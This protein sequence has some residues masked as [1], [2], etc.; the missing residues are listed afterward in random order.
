MFK[1]FFNK[2]R[3]WLEVTLW[4]VH[5][6]TFKRWGGGRW[7]YFL[8]DWEFPDKGKLGELHFVKS[9]LRFDLIVHEV[10]HALAEWIHA[11]RT[12]VTS[13]NE[14][15]LALMMDEICRRLVREL[16]KQGIKL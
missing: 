9:R 4:D 16:K 5:P 8:P 14:E 12:A 13:K 15:K 3:Q 11:N 2:K 10:F 1:V 7:G 6:V